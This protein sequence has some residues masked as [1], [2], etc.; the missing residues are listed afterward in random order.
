RLSWAGVKDDDALPLR[1][2]ESWAKIGKTSDEDVLKILESPNLSDRLRAQQELARRGDKNRPALLELLADGDKT[3]TVRIA[4]LGALQS[5]WNN[6]VQ[7][8]FCKR[9]RDAD[10]GVRRLA[11]EA[12]GRHSPPKDRDIHESLVQVLN[13]EDLAA[14][15]AIY[16][17]MGR[18]AA[19][20][21]AD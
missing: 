20:S 8:E 12:L 15:R 4:A 13:D 6:D 16:L 14:R 3:A 17:A 9:L 1:S 21:A 10:A 7:E 18:I 19:P 11:A 2:L 5:M